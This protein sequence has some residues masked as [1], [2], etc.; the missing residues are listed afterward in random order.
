MKIIID[1]KEI[2]I[3]PEYKNIVSVADRAKI[4]TPAPCYRSDRSNGCCQVCVVEINGKKEYACVTKPLD[5]MNIIV[6]RD[7]LNKIRK[8]RIKK[9]Q[10]L[11]KDTQEACGCNCDCSVTTNNCC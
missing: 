1:G 8:E 7:D 2:E 3:R 10:E 9:Y 11:P 5:G 4:G 6:N